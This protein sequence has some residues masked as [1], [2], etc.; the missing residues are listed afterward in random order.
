MATED[1]NGRNSA[2][3]TPE[4]LIIIV[5]GEGLSSLEA[6]PRLR[7]YLSQLW[8]RRFYIF[9][10]AR[11]RAFQSTRNYRLWRMWLIVEPMLNAVVYG[12]L[13]GFLFKASH[14][15]ENFIGFLFLGLTFMKM[16]NGMITG[17]PGL[18]SSNRS[19]IRAFSFP[20]ASIPIS[21]SLRSMLDNI[22]PAVV[23]L[24][25]AFGLQWGTYPRWT[26][27]LIIPIFLL[28]HVFGCGLVMIFARL[29]AEVPDVRPLIGVLAQALF[30]LS[31]VMYSVERFADV[32]VVYDIMSNNPCYIFLTAVRDV[33]IYGSLP[34]ADT[35]IHLLSWSIGTFVFGFI[36]FWRAEEKYV[37]LA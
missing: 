36:Y 9:A 32:P 37:R 28:L 26:L 3:D 31:G 12:F 6:R 19:M 13:F 15:V 1:K 2:N 16:I 27:I 5:D 17:G 18:I 35:W 29:S 22:L 25:V 21:Y 30:F 7:L 10:E 11:S 34:S 24:I 20:R 23:A 8:Q 4:S 14:D 33:S